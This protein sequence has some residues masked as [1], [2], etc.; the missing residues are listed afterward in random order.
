MWR[1]ILQLLPLNFV[2]F[3]SKFELPNRGCGLSMGAA[4]TQNFTVIFII[5]FCSVTINCRKDHNLCFNTLL[6][7]SYLKAICN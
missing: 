7:S 5:T 4:Y 6:Y 1:G 3:F 2:V